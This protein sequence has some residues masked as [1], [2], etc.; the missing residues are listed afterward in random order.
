LCR[1]RTLVQ[2]RIAILQWGCIL[3][4]IVD[5]WWIPTP[6][7]VF[8]QDERADATF[9]HFQS[10]VVFLFQTVKVSACAGHVGM[11][12]VCTNSNSLFTR[13]PNS[14]EHV[15]AEVTTFSSRPVA[16]IPTYN[17]TFPVYSDR[18]SASQ[19]F[20]TVP[21]VVLPLQGHTSSKVRPGELGNALAASPRSTC[22]R[23]IAE[24]DLG[25]FSISL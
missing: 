13:S 16:G 15:E 14:V 5:P 25:R 11:V 12:T 21:S 20:S 1:P 24:E 7:P 19:G 9:I 2:T 22:H 10:D 4:Y 23:C 8:I 6:E 18:L 3:C 17:S